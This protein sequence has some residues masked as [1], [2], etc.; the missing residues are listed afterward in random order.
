MVD[1]SRSG[2]VNSDPIYHKIILGPQVRRYESLILL[3]DTA[4]RENFVKLEARFQR[5]CE[6]SGLL[7]A[8]EGSKFPLP[9]L[10]IAMPGS[11]APDKEE[12][13]SEITP[14]EGRKFAARIG[15]IFTEM[16]DDHNGLKELV[17]LIFLKKLDE[18]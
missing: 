6:V 11:T 1:M 10:V 5:I 9:V 12:E 15:A 4:D 13:G 7:S 2:D 18:E 3:Y 16:G 17:R 8:D 14:E